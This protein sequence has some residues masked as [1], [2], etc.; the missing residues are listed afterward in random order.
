MTGK[1]AIERAPMEPF[2]FSSGRLPLLISMPHQGT[3]IPET[4]AEQLTPEARA[5][6]DTDWH[7]PRLYDFA[8]AMGASLLIATHSRYVIDLNRDP[9]GTPL[10]PGASN[11]ELCPT[12]LFSEAALY[13]PGGEP[14]DNEIEQRRRSVWEPYHRCLHSELQRLRAAHGIALLLDAH[15]IRSEVPRFFAGRLPDLNLGTADGASADPQLAA[16]LV[17]LCASHERYSSV[18]D[19]RFKG[20]YIT[21]HYGQP[22]AGIHAVQLEISQRTYMNEDPPYEF[23]ANLA[24]EL[25]PLL[26]SFIATMLAWAEGA[27]R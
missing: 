21:R 10:Y 24:H 20:G 9:E 25:R 19:G 2:I 18:L 8:S 7:L 22:L 6:P 16:R 15:S 26:R 4:I 11:S 14:D 1:A 17:A 27:R 12:A 5:V 13:L 23:S 3:Y